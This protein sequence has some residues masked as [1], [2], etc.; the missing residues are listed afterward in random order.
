MSRPERRRL[1]PARWR[2][3]ALIGLA[4]A[5]LVVAMVLGAWVWRMDRL[6]YDLGLSLWTRPPPPG[7]V[8]VA[9]DDA[10]IEAIGRWPWRRAIHA[11]LLEKLAEA[12]PKAVALDLVL[13]EPDPDP[14]QDRLLALA[15]QRAA[16]VVLPVAWAAQGGSVQ[17]PSAA[18]AVALPWVPLE[19]AGVLRQA[20]ILGSA[21][22]A[23]DADGV[24]R[25]A[26]LYS[27]PPQALRPHLALAMIEAAGETISPRVA[28]E[29]EVQGVD[30]ASAAA[31]GAAPGDARGDARVDATSPHWQRDGRL[32]IRYAGPPGTVERVSYVE[33]LQGSVP[34]ERLAGRHVLVGLTAQGLGDT[35]ATPVNGWHQAMPGVE[36]LANTLY[37]L[38]SGDAMRVVDER[39]VAAGSALAVMLLLASFGRF[40][41]RVALPLALLCPPVMIAAS[42]VAIG[43]GLWVGPVPLALTAALAYP[44]WSWRRLERAVVTL[45]Q[46]IATLDKELQ[47]TSGDA[48]AG[49]PTRGDAID[50]RLQTLRRAGRL[51]RETRRFL[52]DAVA[53]LPT[54]VLVADHQLRVTLAN[55]KAAALYEVGSAD[56]LLGL[57][58]LRLLAELQTTPPFDWTASLATLN[59]GDEGVAVQGHMAGAGDYVVHVAALDQQGQRSLIVTM[60]DVEPVKQAEREREEALA[61]VSHDLRSPATSIVML[62]DLNLQGAEHT[63]RDDLLHEVRRLAARTVALSESYV[64]AAQARSQP[65]QRSM[66]EVGA[67]MEDSLVDLRAQARAADV[68]LRATGDAGAVSLS[69]DR[70]QLVRALGNLVSNAIKHSPRGATV[71]LSAMARRGRLLLS[72]RDEGPGLQPEQW[73]LVNE[74]QEGL[75]VRDARGVGLGL[76]FVQRVAR[77]HD[78]SLR[79]HP[80]PHGQGAIF[81]I[82]LPL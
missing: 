79:A 13:S 47:Q 58:L 62:A 20:A 3:E 65:L 17:G 53:A 22:S 60:A 56:E 23:V 41:P 54:A 52:K 5:G 27:G 2:D 31:D 44:L 18:Q 8:I 38:R 29:R 80:G 50:L 74:G 11:S 14:E 33:V 63:S 6:V 59:V 10:S 4:L 66:Q 70:L 46:E 24:L 15:L 75:P 21:E 73:A 55:P 81:E 7:I 28:V 12:R 32:L 37:T 61:F 39:W 64:R 76:L 43:A 40:G 71:E 51:M 78:G 25:N 35:L 69:V 36:V 1:G 82:E 30:R 19:P 42:L 72:V 67:L 57:D 49:G 48:R 34:A 9:I 77:R 45:D 16:P 26:F 68:H